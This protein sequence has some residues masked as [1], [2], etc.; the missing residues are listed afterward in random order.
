MIDTEGSLHPLL[1]TLLQLLLLC[2]PAGLCPRT[3]LTAILKGHLHHYRG[4][5]GLQ[6]PE[7]DRGGLNRYIRI[8]WSSEAHLVPSQPPLSRMVS[9]MIWD[10][11]PKIGVTSDQ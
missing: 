5:G 1:A 8:Y 11:R 2:L 9:Q 4:N 10:I 6:K 7:A 3:L